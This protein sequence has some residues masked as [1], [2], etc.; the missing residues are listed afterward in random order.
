MWKCVSGSEFG[1]SE[2]GMSECGMSE[3]G[4]SECG[5]SECGRVCMGVQVER[6]CVIK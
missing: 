4:M 6:V 1:M 3:C 5:M 2:C